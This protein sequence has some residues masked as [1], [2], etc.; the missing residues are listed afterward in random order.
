MYLDVARLVHE[1]EP[2]IG[3]AHEQEKILS[4]V[5]LHS[6]MFYCSR[7]KTSDTISSTIAIPMRP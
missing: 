1:I 6:I 3:L 4:I 7:F 5:D 2:S